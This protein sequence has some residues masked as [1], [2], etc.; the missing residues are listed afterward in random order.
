MDLKQLIMKLFLIFVAL[1]FSG[2]LISCDKQLLDQIPDNSI[3]GKWKL[4]QTLADPGDG[5]GTWYSAYRLSYVTIHSNGVIECTG[6]ELYQV[7]SYHIVDSTHVELVFKSS[8]KILYRF[9]VKNPILEINA[10]CREACGLRY[11]KVKD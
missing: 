3:I 11:I 2:L 1:T 6:D 5:S 7:Q 10:P 4:Y 8:Q 9:E